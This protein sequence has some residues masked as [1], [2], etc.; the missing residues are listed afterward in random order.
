M[1]AALELVVATDPIAH[2]G[3]WLADR[4]RR[5][6]L[7]PGEAEIRLAIPGGSALA[8]V[9]RA[10]AE[11]GEVWRRIALTWVD[12]RCVPVASGD[13]NRG[14]AM[15]LGILPPHRESPPGPA[16]SPAR[17][18]PLRGRRVSA[19]ALARVARVVMPRRSQT[20]SMWLCSEW[21]PTA[22]SPRSSPTGPAPP[23]TAAAQ[24]QD[25]AVSLTSLTSLIP[26]A[27]RRPAA[28]P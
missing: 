25:S 12:E 3:S 6:A 20:A 13:S 5:L 7:C 17:V 9:A 16:V 14:E 15:R 22:M 1:P 26:E 19:E 23:R 8:A 21:V 10:A 2:A 11:L 28:S 24:S 18:L 27:P 4:I